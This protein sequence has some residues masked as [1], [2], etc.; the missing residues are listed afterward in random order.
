MIK[1][2]MEL[3]RDEFIFGSECYESVAS[4]KK[5]VLR[6]IKGPVAEWGNVNRNNR[7]YSE[8]LW[9]RVLE[10][11]YVTEQ[12]ANKTLYGEAN[13]PA[14]R[15]DVD[16]SRVSHNIVEMHKV[17]DKN[18][19]FATIDVLDTPLGN[20]LNVLYEYGSVIGYSSRAGGVLHNRKTHIDVDED[21]YHFITFDAVP[22]PSVKSARPLNEGVDGEANTKVE[23]SE[24]AHT[25]LLNIIE[26]AGKK[27]KE[28]LKDFIYNLQDYNLDRELSVLEGLSVDKNEA[29]VAEKIKDTTLCLL[30]ESYRQIN[31]LKAEKSDVE[32]RVGE[33][34]SITDDYKLKLGSALK[35]IQTLTESNTVVNEGYEKLI[36]EKKE[37]NAKVE[38]LSEK[39]R[40]LLDTIKE[41][42]GSLDDMELNV[43]EMDIF[44]S[45]LAR[46]KALNESKELEIRELRSRLEQSVNEVVGLNSEVDN[47]KKYSD[48]DEVAKELGETIK[49]FTSLREN[50]DLNV[51]ELSKNKKDLNKVKAEMLRYVEEAESLSKE[52]GILSERLSVLH[53]DFQSVSE[54]VVTLNETVK[55]LTTR[56]EVSDNTISSYRKDL[57][58]S[59]C[60]QY[61][62]SPKILEG[63]LSGNFTADDV[64]NLCESTAIHS[65]VIELVSVTEDK[66]ITP[67]QEKA[68]YKKARLGG[69]FEGNR[70]GKLTK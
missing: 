52:K 50:F 24:E 4:K 66:V 61:G 65:N 16:F 69:M 1:E 62:L 29:D 15:F 55:A 20:I 6:T 60:G 41:Y 59:I 42:E 31:L 11:D 19:V 21:S 67:E 28:T 49:E 46:V 34:V 8:K 68:E 40:I 33:S 12:T 48:Y 5:G 36:T 57:I 38:D 39:N 22:Y 45:E 63:K 13:H 10:S 23:I 18:M 70:R 30:K 14:D 35:K 44:K 7:K 56:L 53:E 37:L 32:R 9:D 58:K 27:D 26:E 47:Y 51:V 3:V 17:P 25:K 64:H 2:G 43:A 54:Q